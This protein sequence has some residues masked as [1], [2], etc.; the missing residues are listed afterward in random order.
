MNVSGVVFRP[1]SL[2][3]LCVRNVRRLDSLANDL[4]NVDLLSRDYL[5]TTVGVFSCFFCRLWS[6]DVPVLT[7]QKYRYRVLRF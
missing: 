4:S 3:D 1:H 7:L 6:V 2:M 5:W